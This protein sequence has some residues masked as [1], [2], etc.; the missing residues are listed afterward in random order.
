MIADAH[1]PGVV[2]ESCALRRG[3]MA[4][5]IPIRAPALPSVLIPDAVGFSAGSEPSARGS[6]EGLSIADAI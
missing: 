1:R 3:A 2:L 4:M 5:G 6:V